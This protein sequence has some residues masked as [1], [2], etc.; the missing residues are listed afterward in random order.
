MLAFAKNNKKFDEKTTEPTDLVFCGLIGMKDP[1][2][3]K[4]GQSIAR[5]MQGGVHVIMITGDSPTTAGKYCQTNRYPCG[6][7]PCCIDR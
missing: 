7:R 5:L 2:R 6:W 4:V 1:P 3:P